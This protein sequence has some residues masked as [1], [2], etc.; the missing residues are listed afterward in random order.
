MN[1]IKFTI[2]FL[3]GNRGR[4]SL[5]E[6]RLK[7]AMDHIE[8][9][10][11]IL[12]T[13]GLTQ[14]MLARHIG[15]SFVSLNAWING[16]AHPRPGALQ[17][18]D[19]LYAELSVK[20]EE[21]PRVLAPRL[22]RQEIDQI[23]GGT[24]DAKA[25][26][27]LQNHQHI[28]FL[29]RLDSIIDLAPKETTTA[30]A[31]LLKLAKKQNQQQCTEV[32]SYPHIA[33]WSSTC[34]QE[35]SNNPDSTATREHAAHFACI[36]AV[37]AWK[38]G[39]K[40]F[41]IEVPVSNGQLILPSLGRMIFVHTQDFTP[42]HALLK[43]REGQIEVSLAEETVSLPKNI[44]D[45][46]FQWEPI[47]T[48]STTRAGLTLK[49]AIDD[50]DPFRAMN[51]SLHF[52]LT[53]VR[54]NELEY[55]ELK[56]HLIDAWKTLADYHHEYALGISQGVRV[57]V[58]I[59]DVSR[60]ITAFYQE[61]FG[62][63]LSSATI[64]SAAMAQGMIEEF[65]RMKINA[66]HELTP[67]YEVTEKARYFAPWATTP[68]PL[69]GL[70]EGFYSMASS[71]EFWQEQYRHSF[72][73]NQFTAA[74]HLAL[75]KSWENSVFYRLNK[76]NSLTADGK[77][78][79]NFIHIRSNN[80]QNIPPAVIEFTR[81]LSIDRRICFR[82]MNVK[83][84]D[85]DIERLGYAWIAGMTCPTDLDVKQHFNTLPNHVVGWKI[86]RLLGELRLAHPKKFD[87]VINNQPLLDII[88]PGARRADAQIAA[89]QFSEAINSYKELINEN[90]EDKEAWAGLA[91]AIAIAGDDA[92]STLGRFP[93]IVIEFSHYLQTNHE[94][95]APPLK[96][97]KW[98]EP[99]L[100]RMDDALLVDEPHDS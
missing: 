36:A 86:R 22:R 99:L 43:C 54:L 28:A 80:D 63:V 37:A 4:C 16:R 31:S 30:A 61:G 65:Q 72:G 75:R 62:A 12:K 7:F 25:I 32:L 58:P 6:S 40:N 94:I 9:L 77:R 14:E 84:D 53:S 46:T 60:H 100:L 21:S 2:C 15:V 89:D 87:E 55:K 68:L 67:L 17:I 96:L 20:T 98:L 81:N 74:S 45:S 82:L 90:D 39:V 69:G 97:A 78:M 49:V 56:E 85:A 47:R 41:E 1:F 27:V 48:I 42:D 83:T 35:I 19:D 18:I 5:R 38:C 8:K 76:N 71:A 51:S 70:I 95:S 3:Y 33:M 24:G 92:S 10:R 73:E 50:V 64:S 57:I 26:A 52:P 23:L 13:G 11:F 44:G 91:C 93:E 59:Q 29:K 66:L 79:L 88:V 34:L